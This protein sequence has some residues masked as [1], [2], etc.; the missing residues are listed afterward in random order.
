MNAKPKKIIHIDMDCF[1]AAIEM[2][3]NPQLQN[4]P[5]AVGGTSE[6]SVLCTA[7]YL[8]R[9][10]GIRSAMAT[11]KALQL[12]SDLVV[13]PVNMTKYKQA[14]GQIQKIF[15]QFTDLVE[16]LALDEAYLDVTDN[17]EFNN[18]ATLTAKE[19]KNLILQQ[20]QLTASAGIAPNKFLAK[21]ASGW[22][23]PNGLFTISP[24]QI[25]NF[26]INLP[27]EN[28]FGVGKVTLQKLHKLNIKTCND[29]QQFSLPALVNQFGKFGNTLYYQARG[30]DN[31]E[32][33][34]NR[35]RKSVSVETTFNAD[36]IGVNNLITHLETLHLQLVSRLEKFNS[37]YPIKN[38]FIKLKYNN[39]QTKSMETIS[40][41]V[42]LNNFIKLLQKIDPKKPVRLLGIGITFNTENISDHQQPA[43]F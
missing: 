23:K 29:L 25:D 39:F 22:N 37:P 2:R 18:S 17:Q 34:P 15:H 16:P 12:C 20:T 36:I 14:S 33:N 41:F 7:N 1:Y 21:I 30:I 13:I 8:A 43:L 5:V 9:K 40:N 42:D 6:R 28:I 11:K 26:I 19:I 4:K 35:E 3:D 27:V 31:R 38:Q 32:V 24:E 10:F